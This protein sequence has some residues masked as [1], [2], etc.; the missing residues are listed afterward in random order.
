MEPS[1]PTA[2]HNGR[3]QAP[4]CNAEP[5]HRHRPSR[6]VYASLVLGIGADVP[7]SERLDDWGTS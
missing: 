1:T 3:S 6:L 7:S 5:Q 4:E 2:D